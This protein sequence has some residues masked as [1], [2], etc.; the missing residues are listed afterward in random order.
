MA[1]DVASR[2]RGERLAAIERWRLAHT[3]LEQGVGELLAATRAAADDLLELGVHHQIRQALAASDDARAGEGCGQ[4]VTGQVDAARQGALEDGRL[5]A[6]SAS[7][8]SSLR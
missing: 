8:S 7:S 3:L 4:L 1:R 6:K 2:Q 5:F